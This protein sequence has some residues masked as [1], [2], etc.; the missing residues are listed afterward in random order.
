MHGIIAI[1]QP[2]VD[3]SC[4]HQS[5]SIVQQMTSAAISLNFQPVSNKQDHFMIMTTSHVE[6]VMCATH[7]AGCRWSCHP[8]SLIALL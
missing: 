2:G 7:H 6:A 8:S 4:L 1:G 3:H 5:S